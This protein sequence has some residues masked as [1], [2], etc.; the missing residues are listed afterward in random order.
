LKEVKEM[1]NQHV[2]SPQPQAGAVVGIDQSRDVIQINHFEALRQDAR[3]E[4][5]ERIKERRSYSI[6][7]GIALGAILFALKEQA[8]MPQ[9]L[10]ITPVVS[11][12]FTLQ[13]LSSYRVHNLRSFYLC[14]YIEPNL[15]R[16]C[17]ND[18]ATD[19]PVPEW[20]IFY[21]GLDPV[22]RENW[23]ARLEKKREYFYKILHTLIVLFSLVWLW[24]YLWLPLGIAPQQPNATLYKVILI[25]LTIIYLSGTLAIYF[26]DIKREYID[27]S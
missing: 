8:F 26:I 15:K 7:L 4:I 11:F 13:I 10:F 25:F 20:E 24:G 21:R 5:I 19:P 22:Y 14:K 3:N 12:Y 2:E 18:E 23:F 16:L 9:L 27:Y 6:Q 17:K 1:A